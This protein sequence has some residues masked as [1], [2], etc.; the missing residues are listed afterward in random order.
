MEID[1]IAESTDGNS[2][3]I[4]ECKWSDNQNTVHLLKQLREK[5]KKLPFAANKEIVPVLFL[6]NNEKS[7][8]NILLP[9]RVIEML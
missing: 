9:D 1:V 4:G 5:A 2:L 6:K 7:A 3:L 8:E